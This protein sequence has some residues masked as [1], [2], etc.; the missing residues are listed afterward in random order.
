M[1]RS[2]TLMMACKIEETNSGEDFPIKDSKELILQMQKWPKVHQTSVALVPPEEMWEPIQKARYQAKDAGLFRW[3]PHVNLLYPFFKV[4]KFD[5]AAPFLAEALKNIEPFTVT[6]ASFG[7]FER[8]RSTTL[9]LD[10]VVVEGESDSLEKLQLA[11][12]D[13]LPGVDAQTKNHGGNFTP[14][15]TVSHFDT[16]EEAQKMQSEL[17][18]WWEPITFQVS[19]VH[20]IAR[21][22]PRSQFE[23]IYRIHLPVDVSSLSQFCQESR[24]YEGMPKEELPFMVRRNHKQQPNWKRRHSS[25]KEAETADKNKLEA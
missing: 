2:K 21:N 6:L 17:E 3:P 8:K 13:S 7:R 25:K 11:L 18:E 10:P 4:D 9:W 19:E 14:H 1:I 20:M 23:L 22:G 16:A 5:R 15:M 24:E 12:Q